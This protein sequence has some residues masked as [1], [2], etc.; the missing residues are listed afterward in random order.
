[1][2]VKSHQIHTINPSLV[3]DPTAAALDYAN[4]LSQV[5]GPSLILD[6]IL[7]GMVLLYSSYLLL[8]GK[9][10]QQPKT[11]GSRWSHLLPLPKPCFVEGNG[12]SCSY[13]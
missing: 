5:V 4:T 3:S 12:S 6:V 1:M 10:F 13:L 7:L 9:P 8:L 2:G 11:L